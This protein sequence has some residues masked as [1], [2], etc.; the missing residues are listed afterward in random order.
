MAE[1]NVSRRSFIKA[2]TG[3]L[4]ALAFG[5]RGVAAHAGEAAENNISR[6]KVKIAVVQQDSRPGQVEKNRRKALA[7]A[8]EA[9]KNQADIILFQEELLVGYVVN[10]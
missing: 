5:V 10:L 1:D 9:L 8:E 2:G 4:G 7:F 3:S 6:E